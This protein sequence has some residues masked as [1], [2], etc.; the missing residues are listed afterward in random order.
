MTQVTEA[1]DWRGRDIVDADGDKVGTLE[2]LFRDNDT[3][4]PEW[5]VVKTGMF[6]T[7]LS[8][9]PI[10][11]AEPTGEDVR[12][13]Y[14]KEQ[15]NDAPRIDDSDGQLSQ[16]EEAQL[17]E[18][19]GLSA[20]NGGRETTGHDTSGPTTDEAMTRSEEELKVGKAERESGRARLR[21]Y[22]VTEQVQTTVPVR[23]EEVRIEREPITD[24]NVDQAL[25]G[26][27]ISEEEHE[28]VL[29]EEEPVVEKRT[30]PKERVRMEKESVTDEAQISEEVRKEQ[31]EAEGDIER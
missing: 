21:K 14:S 26:P 28:V 20:S 23:R 29:H 4:Q 5:A 15:I 18:H 6:G 1:Y 7:K 16:E 24:G 11:G 27:A 25:E 9:V 22:V 3:Q 8:F 13:P 12:V 2:E 10:Q 17:Y 31:I 30:V 19:Y